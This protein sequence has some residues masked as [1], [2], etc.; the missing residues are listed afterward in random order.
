MARRI[1]GLAMLAVLLSFGVIL[2]S[3]SSERQLVGRWE[4][5]YGG[6]FL[7]FFSDGRGSWDGDAF[8]WSADRG[9]L[10]IVF[11]WGDSE[12]FDFEVSRSTLT[13]LYDGEVEESFR[14]AN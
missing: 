7:D 13:F 11:G 10:L 14:R 1:F 12:T 6:G 4:D 5:V 9:R 2:V 3:C 8:T